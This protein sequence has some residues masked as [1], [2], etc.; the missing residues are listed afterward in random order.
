MSVRVELCIDHPLLRCRKRDVKGFVE[1]AVSLMERFPDG[2]LSLALLSDERVGVLHADF[3]Q[4]PSLTDVITF[5]GDPAMAFA[6]EICVSVDRAAATC[7]EHKNTFSTELSLYIV[8]GLLHLAGL[9]DKKPAQ[10]KR[11]REEEKRV[12]E[13]LAHRN[14][15]PQFA[16]DK[17]R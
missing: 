15:L 3:L 12:M 8:H 16:L 5:P 14:V 11:M 9:D 10:V 1:S 17:S 4:D 2:E 6:G 13:I 7:A